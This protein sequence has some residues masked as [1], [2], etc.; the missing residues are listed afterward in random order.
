MVLIIFVFVKFP[1]GFLHDDTM[2]FLMAILESTNSLSVFS[3]NDQIFGKTFARYNNVILP[4]PD[5]SPRGAV[6]KSE[7]PRPAAKRYGVR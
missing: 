3:L 5:R 2:C 7:P 6:T 4:I 1:P